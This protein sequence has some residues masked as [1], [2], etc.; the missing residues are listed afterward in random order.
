MVFLLFWIIFITICG[1]V[2]ADWALPRTSLKT[3]RF[4]QA[5][6][7]G[8][9]T[10]LGLWSVVFFATGLIVGT[11]N[12][13]TWTTSTIVILVLTIGSALQSLFLNAIPL[14][15]L[16]R[17]PSKL[18]R[19]HLCST[20]ILMIFLCYQ[21]F[22]DS[23]IYQNEL[24]KYPSGNW[25]A[26]AIYNVKAKFLYLGNE[27]WLNLFQTQTFL[28]H[29]DYPLLL[30]V[31][32]ATGWSLLGTSTLNWP[33]YLQLILAISTCSAMTITTFRLKGLLPA[34]MVLAAMLATPLLVEMTTWQYADIPL[35]AYLTLA[36]LA[37]LLLTEFYGQ[38]DE[39]TQQKPRSGM[40]MIASLIAL[41]AWTKNEGQLVCLICTLWFIPIVIFTRWRRDWNH[42]LI[43]YALGLLLP[44]TAVIVTKSLP[45]TGNDLFQNQ[46][47][48]TLFSRLS[49]VSRIHAISSYWATIIQQ[50]YLR[51]LLAISAAALTLILTHRVSQTDMLQRLF[52]ASLILIPCIG[53]LVGYFTI[54]L[55][56]PHDLQWHLT[57][58]FNRIFSHVYPGLLMGIVMLIPKTTSS[59][60]QSDSSARQ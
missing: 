36:F 4:I 56:T 15:N 13:F 43:A 28:A 57:T 25:D 59:H 37:A 52:K 19:V 58:S 48:S 1:S 27:H 29:Q 22:A 12:R 5:I 46:T 3:I 10:G 23:I 26:W 54:Y 20:L 17:L 14:D 8:I 41:A 40:F 30:P 2:I 21:L 45:E 16:Q 7:F 39:I 47:I 44:I 53:T 34:M 6:S 32:V 35:M 31:L 38:P 50:H 60:N 33:L 18:S 24:A 49:D 9:P 55:I 42:L 11:F 51:P